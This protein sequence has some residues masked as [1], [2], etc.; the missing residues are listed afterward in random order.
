MFQLSRTPA[1]WYVILEDDAEPIENF[2]AQL[3]QALRH[4]PTQVVSLYLGRSNP[5]HWQPTIE[6]ALVAAQARPDDPAAWIVAK[7]LLHCVGYAVRADILPSIFGHLN[8][9]IATPV[10]EQITGWCA[11]ERVLVSYTVPSLV[12]HADGPSV[13]AAHCDGKPRSQPRKAWI[14][15]G[16]DKWKTRSI[17]MM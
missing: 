3:A 8:P 13:M 2:K 7:H 5:T 9:L 1:D 16:R 17:L 14:T 4:A 6:R 15:G 11:H 10:D 12:D